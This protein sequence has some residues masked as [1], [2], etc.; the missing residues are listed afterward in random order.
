MV[1]YLC[2]Q[3]LGLV[4]RLE[5]AHVAATHASVPGDVSKMLVA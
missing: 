3:G 4:H 2:V 5:A 1:S